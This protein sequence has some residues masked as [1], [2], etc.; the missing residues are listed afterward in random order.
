M[1]TA[2]RWL[3]INIKAVL[4]AAIPF[5]LRRINYT[6][7]D[8]AFSFCLFKNITGENCCGCGTL[9]GISALLHLDFMSMIRLNHLNIITIPLLVYVY[10]KQVWRLVQLAGFCFTVK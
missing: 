7:P 10:L 3:E 1:A 9:R 2:T 5:L 4:L 8:D 6:V